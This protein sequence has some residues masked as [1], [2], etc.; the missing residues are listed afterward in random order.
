MG[1]SEYDQ[2]IKT[3]TVVQSSTGTTHVASPADI[4]AFGKQAKPVTMYVEFDVPEESLIKTNEG[5]AKI[6][7]PDSLEGCLARHKGK[8]VPEMPKAANI[9]IKAHKAEAG[10]K[11]CSQK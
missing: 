6:I 3:G 5:W 1:E 9:S 4:E 10:I 8:P 2:M 7:G 11:A